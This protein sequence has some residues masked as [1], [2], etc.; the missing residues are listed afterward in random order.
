METDDERIR[1]RAYAIWEEEGR[2]FGRDSE[3]WQRAH[4]EMKAL[5]EAASPLEVGASVLGAT[6]AELDQVMNGSSRETSGNTA[7]E[8]LAQPKKKPRKPVTT[9]TR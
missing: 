6:E 2:P 4:D 7:A 5:S 3:H 1:K 8:P 9:I